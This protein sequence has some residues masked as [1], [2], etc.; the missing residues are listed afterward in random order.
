MNKIKET[1]SFGN[2]FYV[3]TYEP[4]IQDETL[5]IQKTTIA[6][7]KKIKQ[8]EYD[9]NNKSTINYPNS[10]VIPI[11]SQQKIDWSLLSRNQ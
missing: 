8:D 4:P 7:N 6:L 1:Y 11:I 3:K 5:T 2:C 9:S 10:L